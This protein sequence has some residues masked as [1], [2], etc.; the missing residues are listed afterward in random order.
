MERNLGLIVLLVEDYEGSEFRQRGKG[1]HGLHPRALY[2]KRIVKRKG[3]PINYD[4]LEAKRRK[5]AKMEGEN[6]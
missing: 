1:H 2:G 6:K 4:V 5:C 3:N